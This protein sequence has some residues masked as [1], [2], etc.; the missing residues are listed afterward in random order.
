MNV[1]VMLRRAS[2]ATVLLAV[3]LFGTTSFVQAQAE[4]EVPGDI[5]N[6]GRIDVFDYNLY[7]SL[8][9]L[10]VCEL[11]ADVDWDCDVDSIDGSLLRSSFGRYIVESPECPLHYD[12]EPYDYIYNFDFNGILRSDRNARRAEIGPFDMSIDPDVYEITL[13]SYDDHFSKPGQIQSREEYYISFFDSAGDEVRRT[14]AISDLP[15]DEEVHIEVTDPFMEIPAGITEIR[16]RHVMYDFDLNLGVDNPNSINPVCFGLRKAVDPLACVAIP[17]SDIITFDEVSIPEGDTIGDQYLATHGVTFAKS[18]TD[19]GSGMVWSTP[20][21]SKEGP[22]IYSHFYDYGGDREQDGIASGETF[23]EWSLTDDYH[24]GRICTIMMSFD[25]DYQ[26]NYVSF[27]L[28][29]VDGLRTPGQPEVYERY[30]IE[31]FNEAGDLLDT[32]SVRSD[33]LADPEEDYDGK[34]FLVELF[35]DTDKIARVVMSGSTNR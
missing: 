9:G 30:V 24:N 29:D 13:V 18:C 33:D 6:S 16:A 12:K 2:I 11:D 34:A 27:D 32:K 1:A 7:V 26:S 22:V 8:F 31:A 25:P 23:G 17:E 21:R 4:G 14:S 5:N 15:D 10:S 20:I 3:F 28:V 35:S 19:V